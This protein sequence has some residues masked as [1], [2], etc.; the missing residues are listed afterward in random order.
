QARV[1]RETA[2][3]Q[4]A[5]ANHERAF[6]AYKDREDAKF[7]HYAPEMNDPGKARELR[8]TVQN[9]LR[10]GGFTDQEVDNAWQGR[11]GIS[12]RDHRVQL[13]VRKAA[14]FDQANARAQQIQRR[15]LP[16]PQSPGTLPVNRRGEADE[17]RINSV[18][19]Q[20]ETATGR[21]AEQLMFE[22]YK[23]KR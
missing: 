7:A 12:M 22:L 8:N 13:L 16:S 5:R 14:M 23:A 15:P 9:M 11:T 10:Q 3:A 17:A 19:R 21:R 6:S 4:Y 18:Q 2:L 20:L 1:Q